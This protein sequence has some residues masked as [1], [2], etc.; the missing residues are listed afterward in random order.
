MS[1]ENSEIIGRFPGP[2]EIQGFLKR[3]LAVPL[4]R[5]ALEASRAAVDEI[6]KGAERVLT[7]DEQ[8]ALGIVAEKLAVAVVEI[9]TW[10]TTEK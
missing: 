2:D 4:L 8:I 1:L 3:E 9:S 5:R 7:V 10:T 6:T